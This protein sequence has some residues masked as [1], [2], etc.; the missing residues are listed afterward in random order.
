MIAESVL[1][2][3]Q[4]AEPL[5]SIRSSFLK[6]SVRELREQSAA[7]HGIR[8]QRSFTWAAPAIQK[9]DQFD[10]WG[11]TGGPDDVH[12]YLRWSRD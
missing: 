11:P 12:L 9:R 10:H 5:R 2:D 7:L 8:A 6:S 1:D 4:P 3:T